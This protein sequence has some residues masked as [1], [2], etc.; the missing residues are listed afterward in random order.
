MSL[1]EL[2]DIADARRMFCE[3][4]EFIPEGQTY[5]EPWVWLS[6]VEDM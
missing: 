2:G 3:A 5:D 1:L 4:V 6:R